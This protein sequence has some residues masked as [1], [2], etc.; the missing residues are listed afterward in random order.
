L[1]PGLTNAFIKPTDG[2]LR[3][4]TSAN[5]AT[6]GPVCTNGYDIGAR[7]GGVSRPLTEAAQNAAS[8]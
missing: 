6:L 8:L 4:L 2:N 7:P 5:A 3:L 1:A